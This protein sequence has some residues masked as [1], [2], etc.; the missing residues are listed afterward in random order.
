MDPFAKLRTPEKLEETQLILESLTEELSPGQIHTD[1][2]F[3]AISILLKEPELKQ[4][5]ANSLVSN[6]ARDS[7]VNNIIEEPKSAFLYGINDEVC[8]E[9]PDSNSTQPSDRFHSNIAASSS[10]LARQSKLPGACILS[11]H[12]A[13]IVSATG[14]F[15]SIFL[16]D[17][18]YGNSVIFTMQEGK[19]VPN[20]PLTK[21]EKETVRKLYLAGI[22]PVTTNGDVIPYRLLS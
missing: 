1:E 21:Q 22:I 20:Y 8:I 2:T 17:K 13:R 9:Y 11:G 19:L 6:S 7:D 4:R 16:L 15:H 12:Y 10:M 5:I 14:K 18:V 3:V